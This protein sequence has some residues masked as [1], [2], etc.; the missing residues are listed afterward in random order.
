MVLPAAA[1]R[2]R[3]LFR[4]KNSLV[5]ISVFN[6]AS[7]L[8]SR[9]SISSLSRFLCS[10]VREATHLALLKLTPASKAAGEAEEL[11]PLPLPLLEVD[12]GLGAPKKD[13]ML[14]FCRG[15]FGS[16]PVI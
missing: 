13:V 3:N 9:V 1:S 11:L 4:S 7:Q 6:C 16:E 15:F 12:S 14:P 10:S 5:T 8:S 2:S